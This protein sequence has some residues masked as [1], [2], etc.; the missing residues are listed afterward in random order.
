MDAKYKLYI[1]N[2]MNQIIG[3]FRSFYTDSASVKFYPA[4]GHYVAKADVSAAYPDDAVKLS[5]QMHILQLEARKQLEEYCFKNGKNIWSWNVVSTSSLDDS[6][7]F[8]TYSY[9]K[10]PNSN[11][12]YDDIKRSFREAEKIC[13][14]FINDKVVSIEYLS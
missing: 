7:A 12:T 8:K 13:P 10:T 14:L 2:K 4:T 5:E 6:A 1:T 3:F 11:L 9:P